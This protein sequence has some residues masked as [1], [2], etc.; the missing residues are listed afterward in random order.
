[1]ELEC[2]EISKHAGKNYLFPSFYRIE[3]ISC[4]RRPFFQKISM[5]ANVISDIG[6]IQQINKQEINIVRYIFCR[7]DLSNKATADL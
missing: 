4:A 7:H 3:A 1:M 2:P 5:L 6:F